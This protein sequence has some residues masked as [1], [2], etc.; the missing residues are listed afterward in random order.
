MARIDV[1]HFAREA[2][3]DVIETG[4]AEAAASA[5]WW[6]SGD[7]R[8]AALVLDHHHRPALE[9]DLQFRSQRPAEEDGVHRP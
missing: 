2:G 6:R 1:P 7:R 4:E 3:C 8:L 5:F 9:N